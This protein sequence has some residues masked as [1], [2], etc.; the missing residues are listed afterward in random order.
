MK[1][2]EQISPGLS[3]KPHF[4]NIEELADGLI[5]NKSLLNKDLLLGLAY[6][7]YDTDRGKD[8]VSIVSE[9]NK[10]NIDE[11]YKNALIGLLA[12]VSSSDIP[13]DQ[14]KPLADELTKEFETEGL[15]FDDED[16]SIT[17]AVNEVKDYRKTLH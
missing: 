12:L 3:Y 1:S 2:L 8:T 16:V 7:R 11:K 17:D 5:A 15:K 13:E 10:L 14:I 4:K 9:I 6:F